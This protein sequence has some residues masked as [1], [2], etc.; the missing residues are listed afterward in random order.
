MQELKLPRHRPVISTAL[1]Q[2]WRVC[3]VCLGPTRCSQARGSTWASG[4]WGQ[5]Q[6][7]V[8]PS[9][10][11]FLSPLLSYSSHI[12]CPHLL[13]V[14]NSPASFDHPD[15]DLTFNFIQACT[16]PWAGAPF[17][18]SPALPS[19]ASREMGSRCCLFTLTADM[20]SQQ[21]VKRTRTTL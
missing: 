2:P 7:T 9:R 8:P 6:H 17:W 11:F 1:V 12:Y 10:L 19:A 3:V 18:A 21:S 4:L 14:M 16:P 5:N 20:S 13:C 15:A